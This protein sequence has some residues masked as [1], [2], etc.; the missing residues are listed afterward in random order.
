VVLLKAIVPDR[1]QAALHTPGQAV[2]VIVPL[3]AVTAV[4]HGLPAAVTAADQD[5]REAAIA[6]DPGL[7]VAVIVVVPGLQAAAA[8]LHPVVLSNQS[9]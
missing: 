4:A 7:Q 9:G 6:V 1:A 8:D 5:L 3:E 2:P